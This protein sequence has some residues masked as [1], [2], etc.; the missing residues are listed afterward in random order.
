MRRFMRRIITYKWLL[1]IVWLCISPSF[2]ESR[3]FSKTKKN[4][5]IETLFTFEDGEGPTQKNSASKTAIVSDSSSSKE[6]SCLNWS[7]PKRQKSWI[8]FTVSLPD[9]SRFS[10]LSFRM[11]AERVLTESDMEVGFYKG[12]ESHLSLFVD[13]IPDEWTTFT[14]P[15]GYMI[16][17]EAFVPEDVD[18]IKWTFHSP[19]DCSVFLDD[20]ALVCGEESESS[21]R[22]ARKAEVV[23]GDPSAIH[24]FDADNSRI[25]IEG[26]GKKNLYLEW[27]IPEKTSFTRLT[28]T[29]L[30]EDIRV[31]KSL[32]VRIKAD[33]PIRVGDFVVQFINTE[34]D[35]L[36]SQLPGLDTKW[37]TVELH[38]AYFNP[39]KSPDPE[40]IKSLKLLSWIQEPATIRIKNLEL[41]KGRKGIKSWEPTEK[42]QLTRIFGSDRVKKVL[43]IE[44]DHFKVLTDTRAVK[45]K[46]IQCLE[47]HHDFIQKNLLFP[48]LKEKVT[49]YIFRSRDDYK[50]FCVRSGAY[51]KD[52][53]ERTAGHCNSRYFATYYK[54]P[55]S[56]IIVHELTHAMVYKTFGS[57]GGSWLHEGF[58]EYAEMAFKK[59]DIAKEFAVNLKNG[60]FTSLHDFLTIRS[61]AFSG[62]IKD[63]QSVSKLYTQAAAFFAFMRKGPFA[64]SFEELATALTSRRLGS[65]GEIQCIESVYGMSLDEIEAKWIEWGKKID[66]S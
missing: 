16:R 44:T 15:L 21:W 64:E 22:S 52:E 29:A 25:R 7:L 24:A 28:I 35:Y 2:M 50:R 34:D 4:A 40:R 8:G 31:F 63:S 18:S 45:G 26:K 58:A 36:S 10:A 66:K 11:R 47:D 17:S 61:L 59:R 1:L 65:L 23:L 5:T 60:Q 3:A 38:L 19:P 39:R 37:Q 32:K 51:T 57:Y 53:A 33:R 62:N 30:P 46:F 48:P 13:E 12:D 14:L 54:E 6:N 43:T 27:E 55:N 41:I 9:I 56:P 49:I 20:V 42:D